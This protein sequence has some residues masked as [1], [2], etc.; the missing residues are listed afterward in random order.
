M[1]MLTLL[2]VLPLCAASAMAQ[3]S[4]SPP[5]SPGTQAAASVPDAA[6]PHRR[7][8]W[9]QRFTQANTSHDG[10]LTLEQAKGGYVTVARHF[11][12]IDADHKGYVTLD[13]IRTWHKQQRDA[14]H[15]AASRTDDRL[16]PRPALHRSLLENRL[17]DTSS[18]GRT[19]PAIP[20]G[21]PPAPP[22]G[23]ASDKP[24]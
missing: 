4:A 19:M 23:M 17:I 1:R 18:A 15:N 22:K 6:A 21:P 20:S 3:P 24:S 11:A 13:D 14:R 9:E 16:R 2:F 7:L 12:Q 8:G 5:P 10:H